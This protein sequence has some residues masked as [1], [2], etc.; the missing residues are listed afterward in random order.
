MA[1]SFSIVTDYS[2][3]PLYSPDFQ[4]ISTALQAKQTKLDTNR[5][6]LQQ[7]RDAFGALDVAKTEDQDYLEQRLQQ[8]SDIS[9]KYAGGDLSN[10]GLT[11][12]LI[13]SM[14]QVLDDNVKSALV[15]T[16]ILRNEQSE[17]ADKRKNDPKLYSDSNYAYAMQNANAWMNDKQTGTAY[18]GGGGFFEYVDTSKL[19]M[20]NIPALEKA[21]HSTW[22]ETVPGQGAFV[23]T[24]TK[25]KVDR[26]RMQDALNLLIN[27]KAR[28]QMHVDAWAKYDNMPD[29]ML[30]QDWENHFNAKL[31]QNQDYLAALKAKEAEAGPQE[32]AMYSEAIKGWES[33]VNEMESTTDFNK[34]VNVY[35]KKGAYTMLADDKFT[36]SFLDAYTYDART[37][38]SD[39]G[40]VQRAEA[41]YNLKQESLEET[42]AHHRTLEATAASKLALTKKELSSDPY[43]GPDTK[44]IPID[45]STAATD[46]HYKAAANLKSKVEDNLARVIFGVKDG[47]A[48]ESQINSV[49]AI[50]RS[51]EF[52]K[53]LASADFVGAKSINIRGKE[54]SF[55]AYTHLRGQLIDYQEEFLNTSQ[56]KKDAFVP[57]EAGGKEMRATLYQAMKRGETNIREL[58]NYSLSHIDNKDGTYSLTKELSDPS[59]NYVNN[60]TDNK[61]SNRYYKLLYK[62]QTGKGLTTLEKKDLQL[63][64][65]MH[66]LNDKTLS[67]SQKAFMYEKMSSDLTGVDAKGFKNAIIASKKPIEEWRGSLSH[68]RHLSDITKSDVK[69][70][71]FSSMDKFDKAKIYRGQL[72][73]AIKTGSYGNVNINIG[74]F[75]GTPQEN[76]A[77]ALQKI[78]EYENTINS[79]DALR[80]KGVDTI[81]KDSFKQAEGILESRYV[82][83]QTLPSSAS[84][85]YSKANKGQLPIYNALV[86][87]LHDAGSETSGSTD[88]KVSPVIDPKTNLPTGDW[89]ISQNSGKKDVG[90]YTTI[91]PQA[92]AKAITGSDIAYTTAKY[93]AG[94]PGAKP[95]NLG[96]GFYKNSNSQGGFADANDAKV[97]RETAAAYGQGG[98]NLASEL[99]NNYKAGRYVV[100]L[101]PDIDTKMYYPV[102]YQKDA[103]GKLNI[104]F[105]E[106]P[107]EP[108]ARDITDLIEQFQGGDKQ[109]VDN[110]IYNAIMSQ[111]NNYAISQQ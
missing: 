17:W 10:D 111:I 1:S 75:T 88:I 100:K 47:K 29:E 96:N 35:G 2:H 52:A 24:E 70:T 74:S 8:V 31:E 9:N 85:I 3:I 48:T 36:T 56:A 95:V 41:D 42:K 84:G 23:V 109:A 14:S 22:Q 105:D 108:V 83:E 55:S 76:R 27:D 19:L 38:S 60:L 92:E 6:K 81:F 18:N 90:P 106:I 91:I 12:N 80:V 16:K 5:Q 20:D 21:L 103:N 37:I 61:Y 64:T 51:P 72:N 49:Q 94:H 28:K 77:L 39:V 59:K 93:N 45:G 110:I 68:D 66:M 33:R 25:E 71:M 63:Y 102:I 98:S 11:N 79:P 99:I 89:E 67:A 73:E 13:N 65:N 4:L 82:G 62:E 50:L 87:K 78:K 15:G 97:L 43:K 46:I 26:G 104:T 107:S 32:K 57:L 40:A 101:I 58:P 44:I 54:I 86:A 53:K 69:G 30:Q 7:A 34:A